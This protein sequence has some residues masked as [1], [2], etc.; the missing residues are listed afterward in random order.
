MD[1]KAA[2]ILLSGLYKTAGTGA[3]SVHG[4]YG[5]I[6]QQWGKD[7]RAAGAS[8]ATANN[9][10]NSRNTINRWGW[11]PF[12]WFY[13]GNHIKAEQAQ[14]QNKDLYIKRLQRQRYNEYMKR[15][16]QNKGQ[17]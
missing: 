10:V 5:D 12:D 13:A 6:S 15:L 8:P 16:E 17:R 11:N 1:K 7:L 3:Q 4:N 2:Y 9:Y 14:E